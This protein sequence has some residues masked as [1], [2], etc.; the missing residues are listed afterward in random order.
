MK[1]E[2]ELLSDGDGFAVLGNPAAVE[3]FMAS[4]NLSPSVGSPPVGA[5]FSA[6]ASI[7]LAG[8][9]L[10]ANSGR[11]V[12]LTKESA[13]AIQR[14]G[15]VKTK[16]PGVSHAM[17]GRPGDIKQWLQ[18]VKTPGSMVTNPAMLAGAA[19]IMAQM[20]M[21][22]QMAEITDYLARID[23]KLDDVL[24]AQTNAVLARMDGVEL[25]VQEAMSV[26][27]TVG[28]VSEVV[29]SKVQHQS[30][31][32]LETQ[33][34]A[35][36]QLGD[37]ADKLDE[38]KKVGDLAD[39]MKDAEAEVEKWLLVLAQ[40]FRLHDA[41]GVLELDRVMDASPDELDRHRLG[42]KTARQERLELITK[43]TDLLLTRM[44]AA[45][46][47]ANSKV[48][49]HPSSSPAVVQSSNEV[50]TEVHDFQQLLGIESSRETS[51]A[52]GWTEAAVEQWDETRS[53]VEQGYDTAK[54]FG[55]K[56]R[57]RARSLR[58]NVSHKIAERRSHPRDG[59]GER[60]E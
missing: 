2:V 46:D 35:L 40:C 33:A 34:Y 15:L 59:D 58:D 51:A 16:T 3:H 38:K 60:D 30:A 56:T 37:L 20:A 27:G 29:W 23:E 39:S 12:K 9:E 47:T 13:E 17:A 55:I 28:R 25:A 4:A 31:T 5:A 6:G 8:S 21:Q 54:R 50:M 45:V 43:R 41:M 22:Q 48:L 49:L 52:R 57:E 10:A 32:I 1:D 24:R 14:Y 11:W 42:L 53:T 7:A 18:I 19:G 26:R 36:R 44:N